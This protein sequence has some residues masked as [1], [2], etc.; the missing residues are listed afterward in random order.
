MD[1]DVNPYLTLQHHKSE[2]KIQPYLPHHNSEAKLDTNFTHENSQ[3]Y[4]DKSDTSITLPH[5]QKSEVKPDINI[6]PRHSQISEAKSES[7]NINNKTERRTDSSGDI[8][9]STTQ[10][11]PKRSIS[12]IK[13]PIRS[14]TTSSI[15]KKVKRSKTI[16]DKK[17][18]QFEKTPGRTSTFNDIALYEP[19]PT[20]TPTPPKTP[21]NKLFDSIGRSKTAT[22]ND[23]KPFNIQNDSQNETQSPKSPFNKKLFDSVG[24]NK[25]GSPSDNKNS[26]LLESTGKTKHSNFIPAVKGEDGKL[27]VRKTLSIIFKYEEA[28]AVKESKIEQNEGLDMYFFGGVLMT[29]RRII[30]SMRT[31]GPKPP[32]RGTGG[33]KKGSIQE[34]LYFLKEEDEDEGYAKTLEEILP[35]LSKEDIFPTKK[36]N[37][38]MNKNRETDQICQQRL[39]R[40]TFKSLNL[41]LDSK[42]TW[43]E[44]LEDLEIMGIVLELPLPTPTSSP[45]S[46]KFSLPQLLTTNKKFSLGTSQNE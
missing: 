42:Q 14:S 22:A 4:E 8:D 46:G 7:S 39:L 44:F 29:K 40:N 5:S 34:S 10:K 24:R 2:P 26:P 19:P 36:Y 25:T 3:K 11:S 18:P 38:N 16:S 12:P 28:E 43:K 23:I 37:L 35:T 31:N 30:P 27:S 33:D 20:D 15:K 45:N 1:N 9:T 6:T 13:S 32:V 17:P 41:N 21:I